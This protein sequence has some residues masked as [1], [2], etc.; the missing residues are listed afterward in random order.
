VERNV[1]DPVVA[2]L[3]LQSKTLKDVLTV[4]NAARGERY[5]ASGQYVS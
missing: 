1:P 3:K 2:S 5:E 4:L